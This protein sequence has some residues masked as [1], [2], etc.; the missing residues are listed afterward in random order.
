M[1]TVTNSGRILQVVTCV[2]QKMTVCIV[3]QQWYMLG[4]PGHGS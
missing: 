3:L 4:Y 1:D 2:Y